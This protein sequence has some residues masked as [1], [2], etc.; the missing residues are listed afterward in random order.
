MLHV[1]VALRAGQRGGAD[2]SLDAAALLLRQRAEVAPGERERGAPA[3]EVIPALADVP[4]DHLPRAELHQVHQRGQRAHMARPVDERLHRLRIEPVELG[5]RRADHEGRGQRHEVKHPLGT[6]LQRQHDAVVGHAVAVQVTA[7][8]VLGHVAKLRPGRGHAECVAVLL[9]E[10]GLMLRVGQQVAAVVHH[11][12][13]VVVGHHVLLARVAQQAARRG[14]HVVDVPLREAAV[15]VERV[16]GEHIVAG[17]Q[18]AQPPR[19]RDGHVVPAGAVGEVGDQVGEQLLVRQLHHLQ[20]GAGGG[21]VL[22]LELEHGS[23][24]GHAVGNQHPDVLAGKRAVPRAARRRDAR[25]H[26]FAR[27]H[28]AG[29]GA[30]GAR[31]GI[32]CACG[33]RAAGAEEG[34]QQ[35][36]D[37]VIRLHASPPSRSYRPLRGGPATPCD[38]PCCA[39]AAA[40]YPPNR[41]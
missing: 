3:E 40:L 16:I 26:Q 25:W 32:R 31:A 5:I 39:F 12:A 22:F 24:D 20:R 35:P 13:I 1:V 14:Q 15:A 4:A 29:V 37:A 23:A 33:A 36:P 30:R 38:A 41:P 2:L 17:H 7:V 34:Q 19:A 9:A 6:R 28:H 11:L 10:G 18:L 27:L 21:L 8:E